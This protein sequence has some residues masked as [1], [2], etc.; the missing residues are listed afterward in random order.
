MLKR[1][2]V[3]FAA[4]GMAVALL[5]L[6]ALAQ[7]TFT[8][9]RAATGIPVFKP[10]GSGLVAIAHGKFDVASTADGNIFQ[11]ARLPKGACVVDG[12]LRGHK[13]DTGTPALDMDVGWAA[14]GTEAASTAGLGDFGILHGD[15]VSG[16]QPETIIYYPL[17]G[18]LKDGPVCF[19]A[20]TI[21][22]VE[23]NTAANAGGN[24]TLTIG[25]YY[26]VP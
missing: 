8:A 25:V 9:D 15:P 17:G 18:S 19:S 6:P 11:L 7:T 10:S 21:I 24:G 20:E 26:Y 2:S 22:Q 14:N 23:S 1:I 16:I 3:L 13:I 4:I 12:F 5:A